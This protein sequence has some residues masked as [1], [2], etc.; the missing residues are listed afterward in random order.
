MSITSGAVL[1][2]FFVFFDFKAGFREPTVFSV[3]EPWVPHFEPVGGITM[4][5]PSH[6]DAG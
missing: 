1:L 5:N 2:D 3:F 4:M 6:Q